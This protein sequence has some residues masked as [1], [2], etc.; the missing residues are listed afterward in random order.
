MKLEGLLSVIYQKFR[1]TQVFEI[2]IL[3]DVSQEVFSKSQRLLKNSVGFKKLKSS[4]GQT[5]LSQH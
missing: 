4:N 5:N 3:S 1:V 2:N